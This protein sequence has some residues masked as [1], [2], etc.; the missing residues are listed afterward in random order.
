M[1]IRAI[2]PNALGP[3]QT[4]M[5]A[6]HLAPW[7]RYELPPLVRPPVKSAPIHAKSTN[8]C[9]KICQIFADQAKL[10][11]PLQNSNV[12]FFFTF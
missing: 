5:D 6:L 11:F 8:G 12:P 4:T 7:Q 9:G 10:I 2:C 1:S 3:I